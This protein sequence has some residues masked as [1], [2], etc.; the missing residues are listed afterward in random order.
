MYKIPFKLNVSY[1][2]DDIEN[3]VNEHNYDL[4]IEVLGYERIGEH[5]VI[6][7]SLVNDKI[8]TFMLNSANSDTYYYKVIYTDFSE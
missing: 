7:R 4:I 8:I 6:V 2:F 3:F 5:I 1:T